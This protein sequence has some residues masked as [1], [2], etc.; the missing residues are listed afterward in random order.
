MFGRGIGSEARMLPNT[1]E[2]GEEVKDVRM[3]CEVARTS[4]KTWRREGIQSLE[5]SINEAEE[6]LINTPS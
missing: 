1:I 5:I 3:A 6:R 2:E 4:V